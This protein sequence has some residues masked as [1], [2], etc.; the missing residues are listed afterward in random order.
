MCPFDMTMVKAMSY[1]SIFLPTY[2]TQVV[3]DHTYGIWFEEMMSFWKASSNAPIYESQVFALF[4]RLAENTVG[5]MD[6]TPYIPG[7][8]QFILKPI[9]NNV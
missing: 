1:F 2:N 4:S 7:I 9:W 8:L 3:K 6:W 5:Y